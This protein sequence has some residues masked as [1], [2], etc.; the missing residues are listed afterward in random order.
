MKSIPGYVIQYTSIILDF[1]SK[2]Q[3]FIYQSI[4]SLSSLIT[5]VLDIFNLLAD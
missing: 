3:I 2:S 4:I 1:K 5:L